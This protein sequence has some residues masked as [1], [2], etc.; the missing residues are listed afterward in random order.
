MSVYAET[1]ALLRW[2]LGADDGDTIRLA[3]ARAEAVFTSR[4]TLIEIE[5]VISR[6]LAEGALS[7][8]QAIECRQ[9]VSTALPHWNVVQL[10][11]SISDRAAQRFPIEP[12]RTLDALHLSTAILI[13]RFEPSLAMLSTDRRVLDNATRLGMTLVEL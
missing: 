4:L 7:E 9:L 13:L 2:L 5:R 10:I 1:S 12:I 8:E 11:E 6:Q 3:L